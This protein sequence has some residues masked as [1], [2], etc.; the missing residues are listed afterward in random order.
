MKVV[1]R[2]INIIYLVCTA[3]ALAMMII[4]PFVAINASVSLPKDEVTQLVYPSIS[5]NLTEEQWEDALNKIEGDKVTVDLKVSIPTANILDY[6]NGSETANSIIESFSESGMSILNTL[7]P[8]AKT[9][10]ET[11]VVEIAVDAVHDGVRT[12]IENNSGPLGINPDEAM[13]TAGISDEYIREFSNTLLDVAAGKKPSPRGDNKILIDDI[14]LEVSAFNRE[15]CQ[16]LKDANV[17]PFN[18]APA[19]VI[20][21]YCVSMDND[22]ESSLITNLTK[23][24]IARKCTESEYE[25]KYEI[26]DFDLIIN[27]LYIAILNK[28]NGDDSDINDIMGY[29]DSNV[30]ENFQRRSMNLL[31]SEETPE[32][33]IKA[34][35]SNEEVKE[36]LIEVLNNKLGIINEVFDK[37]GLYVFIFLLVL[38]APWALF[39]LLTLIRTFR[40]R[41]CWTKT[42][43]VFFFA[44]LQLI[45]GVGLFLLTSKFIPLFTKFIREGLIKTI[46]SSSSFTITTSSFIPSIVYLMFIPLTIIY[47]ILA[48]KIKKDYKEYKREKKAAKKAA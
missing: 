15:V 23:A 32:P 36:K 16:K 5:E 25:G 19:D 31:V 24:T 4:K 22:V 17:L 9:L 46:V 48:H 13:E 6:K 38:M 44:A 10:V 29:V 39:A 11:M 21:N 1:T 27:R 37:Y 8:V 45:L 7:K 34:G 30:E 3:F 43:I 47:V 42:W 40:I 20:E 2:I 26:V 18:T 41:K 14:M 28:I 33:P 12:E 35:A